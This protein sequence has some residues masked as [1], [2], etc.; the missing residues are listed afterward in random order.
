M[1]YQIVRERDL[2]IGK[3]L[4]FAEVMSW[5]AEGNQVIA[6]YLLVRTLEP[7]VVGGRK[8]ASKNIAYVMLLGVCH[9]DPLAYHQLLLIKR[10]N[11]KMVADVQI[12]RSSIKKVVGK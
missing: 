11:E 5:H 12:E 10:E 8:L 7:Q 6:L 9:L 4:L 1:S 2:V 3:V